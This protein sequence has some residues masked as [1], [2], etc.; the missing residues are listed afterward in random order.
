MDFYS[1]Y[2]YAFFFSLLLFLAV[3]LSP[4]FY[5][6]KKKYQAKERGWEVDKTS[7]DIYTY[8]EKIRGTWH[9]IEIERA[10]R[11]GTFYAN[12]KSEVEWKSYPFWAYDRDKII[13]RVEEVFPYTGGPS[14]DEI[15]QY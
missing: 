4:L 8:K 10:Y 1:W 15:G 13:K 11:N 5:E 3:F 12:F 6:A 14:I 9:A 2:T 7:H